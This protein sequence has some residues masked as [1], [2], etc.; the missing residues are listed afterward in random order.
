MNSFLSTKFYGIGAWTWR[1]RPVYNKIIEIEND[2]PPRWMQQTSSY[3]HWV[4]RGLLSTDN[5]VPP[6]ERVPPES[7]T[8][9]ADDGVMTVSQTEHG[10]S[11]EVHTNIIG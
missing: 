7:Q 11:S 9:E 3:Q 4:S 8:I 2:L 1:S 5:T 10:G 6:R